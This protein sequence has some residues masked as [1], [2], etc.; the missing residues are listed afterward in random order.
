MASLP[1]RVRPATAP[2]LVRVSP[3]PTRYVLSLFLTIFL[4]SAISCLILPRRGAHSRGVASC[5]GGNGPATGLYASSSGRRAR[6]RAGFTFGPG[7]PALWRCPPWAEAEPAPPVR[8][9]EPCARSRSVP[10][11][12]QP[13]SR[14]APRA[15]LD[16]LRLRAARPA[17]RSPML[18]EQLVVPPCARQQIIIGKAQGLAL[19]TG[20][21][22]ARAPALRCRAPCIR[23]ACCAGSGWKCRGSAL[24]GSGCHGNRPGY[25]E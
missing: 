8:L 18:F 14:S 19:K 17:A 23:S 10:P 2:N 22:S 6:L 25:R 4:S 15:P 21:V 11:L 3:V 12:Q 9:K 7:P 20:L 16:P 5:G 24:H 1:L 13:S